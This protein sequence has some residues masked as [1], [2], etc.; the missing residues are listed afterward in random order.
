[1]TAGHSPRSFGKG[2]GS[3][4]GFTIVELLVV[5]AIIVMIGSLAL[6]QFQGYRSRARD[7]EREQEIGSLH[8]ALA[9]FVANARTFPIASGAI[10]GADPLS[11]ALLEAG[12]IQAI[13]RDPLSTG[14][15]VYT[16]ESSGPIY[17]LTYTLE[18]DSIPGKKKGLQTAG[19]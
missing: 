17:M 3:R 7:V 15:Y 9:L 1:M 18:T 2:R 11:L 10:T 19:P 13:P 5:T 6:V 12:T 4:A 14:E 16:Y 8:K